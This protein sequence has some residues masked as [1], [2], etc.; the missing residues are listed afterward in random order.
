[1]EKRNGEKCP[2]CPTPFLQSK[3]SEQS[4]ELEIFDFMSLYKDKI[5]VKHLPFTPL[6]MS[7]FH[8]PTLQTMSKAC[9]KSTNQQ[10]N[11]F[12]LVCTMSISDLRIDK[13]SDAE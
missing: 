13:L 9:L 11:F 5:K 1:M 10:Y 4:F 2:P 12:L 7:L 3:N 6:V 8:K